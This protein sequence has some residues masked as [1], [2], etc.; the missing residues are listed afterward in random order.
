MS[1]Q[2]SLTIQKILADA[3]VELIAVFTPAED[4]T[5]DDSIAFFAPGS[6]K[7]SP[8]YIQLSEFRGMRY[9]VHRWVPSE[10][11]GESTSFVDC[12][13]RAT[14]QDMMPDLIRQL[15]TGG[16]IA[17]DAG[18]EILRVTTVATSR[19]RKRLN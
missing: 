10:T 5:V 1:A 8:V 2:E 17:S 12:G 9:G 18:E 4:D 16:V 3:G 14:I 6:A 7:E 13:P 11:G 15:R 19:S